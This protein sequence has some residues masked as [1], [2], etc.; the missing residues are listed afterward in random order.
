LQQN[1]RTSGAYFA[2]GFFVIAPSSQGL[3]PPANPQRL[4]AV[5]RLYTL[6][7]VFLDFYF[8]SVT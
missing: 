2:E 4:S 8:L 1:P 6:R 3:E 5:S 7:L